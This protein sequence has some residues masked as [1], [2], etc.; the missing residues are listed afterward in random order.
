MY[1]GNRVQKNCW[2]R[3]MFEWLLQQVQ[4][5]NLDQDQKVATDCQV[6]G[7][8]MRLVHKLQKP[9]SSKLP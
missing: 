8:E 5:K 1:E 7:Q 2:F 4:A 9:C 3:L 6:E